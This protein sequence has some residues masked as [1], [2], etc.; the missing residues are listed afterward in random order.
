MPVIVEKCVVG[1]VGVQWMG[2]VVV[3]RI[4]VFS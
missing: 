3:L 4:K 1:R 2:V